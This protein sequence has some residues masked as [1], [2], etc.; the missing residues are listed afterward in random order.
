MQKSAL[1]TLLCVFSGTIFG[2]NLRIVNSASLSAASVAPGSIITIFG[3]KL[4]AGVAFATDVQNPPPSLGGATVSVGGSPAGL[5]YV[6][7]TQINA[8]LNSAT[9]TG[10]RTLTVTSS[11]GAQSGNVTIDT[12]AAP[13]LFSLFGTGTRD[14]AIL[15]AITFLLGDFSTRTANSP[16]YLALFATGLNTAAPPS[17]T[18]GGIPV[19]VVFY[20]A[21]P[22][23][24][25]LQ[26][27]NLMLPDSLAG[28]GRVPVVLTSATGHASNTVQ[29]VL[30]PPQG[31]QQFPADADNQTRSRELAAVAYVPGTS[32]VL[33]TD[34][35]DDVVRVVDVIARKVTH[36]IALA[37]GSSPVGIAVDALGSTA[38]VAEA[39]SGKAAFINLSTFVVSGEIPTGGGA[40]AVG[41]GGTQAVVVNQD[42]DSVSI[43]DLTNGAVQKTLPVGR[44]PAGVA[45]DALLKRAYVTNEDD[46]TVSVIDLAGLAVIQTLPLGASVR[47]E[48]IALI[49]GSGV[50]FV[51]V[52]AAGPHGTV[53]LLNLNTG[54]TTTL[55]ANPDRSGGTTDALYYASRIYFANQA[56][57]SIAILPVNPATGVATGAITTLKVD[58]GA[59]ALTVDA[60]DNLLV[61][62]NEGSGTLVL[63][64][65]SA[66]KVVGRINAVQ[67]NLPG[68]DDNDDHTDHDGAA[69]NA[70]VIVSL[71]P[72]SA[73]AGSAF[74]LTIA[75]SN[76]AGATAVTFSGNGGNDKKGGGDFT[77]QNIQVLTG[78]TQLTAAVT[79]SPSAKPGARMVTV[80]TPNG[81]STDR[82]TGGAKFVVLP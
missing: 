21:A 29:V 37:K 52:P 35:N 32:L 48:A 60:K 72:D 63:V 61:V 49:P 16:T 7:P 2:Q 65:L 17:V 10:S 81:E 13:G 45:V 69:S 12:N 36:V 76:L 66:D 57:G 1:A 46:G 53:V 58:L 3:S 43:I 77:V 20:G 82:G 4:A 15:N 5:F 74:T 8:V 23:C 9:P 78:G 38:V 56:G 26:Q 6:S 55:S 39:G 34:E 70:P 24:A 25:G 22:C 59:R 18:I 11:T 31:A 27:I 67:T 30:L 40:V 62:S 73:K 75:G 64:D 50:A 47:P 54:A 68:D 33:V 41:I 79:I 28:A 14:G 51:T 80:T 71:S 19:Q 44:G 42:V